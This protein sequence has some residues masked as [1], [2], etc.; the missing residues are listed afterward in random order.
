MRDLRN[1]RGPAPIY[2]TEYRILGSMLNPSDYGDPHAGDEGGTSTAKKSASLALGPDLV[3]GVWS[4]FGPL[5]IRSLGVSEECD[6]SHP[7]PG[8]L[9]CTPMRGSPE[10]VSVRIRNVDK[11]HFKKG[12]RKRCY[13]AQVISHLKCARFLLYLQWSKARSFIFMAGTF[14]N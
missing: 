14:C 5:K 3:R 12:W 10:P 8:V 6:N 9:L 7:Y 1:T 2:N 11:P 4:S 13:Q